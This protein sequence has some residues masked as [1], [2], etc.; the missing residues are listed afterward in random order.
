MPSASPTGTNRYTQCSRVA[1]CPWPEPALGPRRRTEEDALRR[2]I[3]SAQ[4]PSHGR[5]GPAGGAL[6]WIH[7]RLRG[8][9]SIAHLSHLF[10]ARPPPDAA[11]CR[12]RR[13]MPCREGNG[14]EHARPRRLAQEATVR[15][16]VVDAVAEA[17]AA[18]AAALHD[19]TG[20]ARAFRNEAAPPAVRALNG[21]GP[22]TLLPK[23]QRVVNALRPALV[24]PR[25]PSM[26]TGW[27]GACP[28]S[29]AGHC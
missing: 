5:A 25:R 2:R 22:R 16:L 29:R 27:S 9:T 14:P 10:A 12:T 28:T 3:K 7:V 20:S 23:M 8:S 21:A 18:H 6:L 4:I 15:G 1:A 26:G 19:P 24:D 17:H 13:T 11:H